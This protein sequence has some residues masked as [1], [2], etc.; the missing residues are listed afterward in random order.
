M[1]HIETCSYVRTDSGISSFDY[2]I[3]EDLQLQAIIQGVLRRCGYGVLGRIESRVSRG[4]VVLTGAVPNFFL[5]QKA[6]ALLLRL[7]RV[8]GVRNELQVT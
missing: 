7:D 4:V 6:Q 8:R 3:E 5:K 2:S 1:L